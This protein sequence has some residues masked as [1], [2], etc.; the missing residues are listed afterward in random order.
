M[1]ER[2]CECVLH[3]KW[4]IAMGMHLISAGILML[5]VVVSDWFFIEYQKWQNICIQNIKL[6]YFQY[7]ASLKVTV[8]KLQTNIRYIQVGTFFAIKMKIWSRPLTMC[9][10]Q[11]QMMSFV[12]AHP[13]SFFFAALLFLPISKYVCHKFFRC[14]NWQNDWFPR[15]IDSNKKKTSNT[16]WFLGFYR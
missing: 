1:I 5:E 2:K 3:M 15:L 13:I 4:W 6:N 12:L 9:F 14:P 11:K 16:N 10:N 7:F 8:I